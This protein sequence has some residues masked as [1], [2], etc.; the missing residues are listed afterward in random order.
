MIPIYAS[1]TKSKALRHHICQHIS[2]LRVLNF[3]HS[4]VMN[5][6]VKKN[7]KEKRHAKARRF[8]LW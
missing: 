1:Q 8:R 3:C 2:C 5:V 4:L 6:I 7:F